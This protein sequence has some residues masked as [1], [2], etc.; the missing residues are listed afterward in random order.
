MKKNKIRCVPS[1]PLLCSGVGWSVHHLWDPDTFFFLYHT[2]SCLPTV[3]PNQNQNSVSSGHLVW[4][5]RFSLFFCR[6]LQIGRN[7]SFTNHQ[8]V[9][10]LIHWKKKPWILTVRAYSTNI[11][12]PVM[13]K[14]LYPNLIGGPKKRGWSVHHFWK[15]V[16]QKRFTGAPFIQDMFSLEN[17]RL[18]RLYVVVNVATHPHPLW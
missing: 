10:Q 15:D 17:D 2:I 5:C 8:R 16:I 4:N 18:W 12:I 1:Q 11:R 14:I 9:H 13:S 3:V 6:W 7:N